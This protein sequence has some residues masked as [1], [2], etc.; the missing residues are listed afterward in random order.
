MPPRIRNPGR[1]SN[2]RVRP[3][4]EYAMKRQR[5]AEL[6]LQPLARA[7]SG[8]RRARQRMRPDWPGSGF[9]GL[10]GTDTP[11]L[12]PG[13]ISH[14]CIRM[15]NPDIFR[16]AVGCRLAP[17]SRSGIARRGGRL[18]TRPDPVNGRRSHVTSVRWRP[19]GHGSSLP[20][21]RSPVKDLA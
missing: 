18:T 13:R 15:R 21:W 8:Q 11:Q 2:A 20:Y 16:S 19:G 10:H 14:G 6:V 17:R 12:I 5:L 4:Y 9:V 3:P 1:R 7:E